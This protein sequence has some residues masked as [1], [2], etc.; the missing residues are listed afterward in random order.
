MAARTWRRAL[1]SLRMPLRPPP[2]YLLR[3]EYDGAAYAGWQRQRNA[4]SVQAA[5]EV[6][7]DRSGAARGWAL[8]PTRHALPA[9]AQEAL[10]LFAGAPVAVVGSSRTARVR[11]GDGQR[12]CA[13]T[14]AACTCAQD[15]GVH[16]LGQACHVDLARTSPR[17]PGEQ[18]RAAP[19]S[20]HSAHSR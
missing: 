5:L 10:R 9:G 15:A 2:R 13:L 17:R 7:A 12:G 1:L 3:V 4:H 19:R 18:A 14:L 16:A 11:C 8:R 6:R 20:A